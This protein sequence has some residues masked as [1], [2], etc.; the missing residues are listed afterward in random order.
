MKTL[1]G[2]LH[3]WGKHRLE[4]KTLLNT[5]FIHHEFIIIR[6]LTS[7][8]PAICMV[9]RYRQMWPGPIRFSL[10][11]SLLSP[12]PLRPSR[13]VWPAA[14]RGPSH[15]CVLVYAGFRRSRSEIF[16]KVGILTGAKQG[17]NYADWLLT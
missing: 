1:F 10:D 14:V 4:E 17:V 13:A 2:L 3:W 5:C 6:S 16:R 15:A 12:T 11:D 7:L 8:L 9:P